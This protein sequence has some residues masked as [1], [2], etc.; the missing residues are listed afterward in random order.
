MAFHGDTHESRDW[1]QSGSNTAAGRTPECA[2]RRVSSRAPSQDG[3]PRIANRGCASNPQRRKYGAHLCT[4][5]ETVVSP[6]F[7]R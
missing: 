3:V 6:L 4:S 1:L 7:E 2:S 5:G